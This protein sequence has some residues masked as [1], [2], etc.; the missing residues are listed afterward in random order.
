MNK[1][2]LLLVISGPSG[3]GKGTVVKE[4]IAKRK[5]TVLSVSATTRKKRE[6]ETDGVN[7]HYI[8]V[9]AFEK[10]KNND[11]FLENATF[12]GNSY[13][14]LK[15]EVTER[16]EN[17]INVILEIDV[18]GA[19]K[20]KGEYSEGVFIFITPPTL[21]ELHRRLVERNTE[22]PEVIEKRFAQAKREFTYIDKYNYLVENCDIMASVDAICSIIDAEHLRVLRCYE[23]VYD[24]LLIG[25]KAEGENYDC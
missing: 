20:V 12:C 25:Q 18:Q 6:G 19:M 7:Y 16:L 24:K 13:G 1:K 23:D 15:T 9:E 3:V 8:S 21:E 22:T 17:G 14:T 5:D 11:G 10:I 2:G 4:L